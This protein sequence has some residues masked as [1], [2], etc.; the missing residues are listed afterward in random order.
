MAAPLALALVL[1]GALAA[2]VLLRPR[3]DEEFQAAVETP[4]VAATVTVAA[5]EVVPLPEATPTE[6]PAVQE[7]TDEPTPTVVPPT[8]TPTPTD[9]PTPTVV[10][11]T[12]T[13]TPEETPTP[14]EVPRVDTPTPEDTPTPTE[15]PRVLF[16]DDFEDGDLSG[17]FALAGASS[18]VIDVVDDGT[19]NHVMRITP[20]V[21]WT[22]MANGS[23]EW[24]NYAVEVRGFVAES[25]PSEHEMYPLLALWF[26]V[27][28]DRRPCTACRFLFGA[29]GTATIKHGDAATCPDQTLGGSRSP[30]LEKERWYTLRVEA[31]GSTFGVYVDGEL[32]LKTTDGELPRGYIAVAADPGVTAYYDDVRVFEL[33]SAPPSQ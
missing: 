11:P 33:T 26:R 9:S 25:T 21:S 31:Y 6:V 8:D 12:D 29:V 2:M 1:I 27:D 19:G 10:P 3:G 22:V 28:T 17:W 15:V 5:T 16:E 18:A 24:E 4:A 20:G 13:P 32:V 7:P 14:T 23:S 30:R